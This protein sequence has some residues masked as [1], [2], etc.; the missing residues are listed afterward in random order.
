MSAS[1]EPVSYLTLICPNL[2]CGR[3]VV[4]PTTARTQAIRCTHCQ[5]AFRVPAQAQAPA[6]KPGRKR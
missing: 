4:A 5:T 6:D 1:T 3:M 2:A